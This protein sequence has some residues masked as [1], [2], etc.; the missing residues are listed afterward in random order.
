[1]ATPRSHIVTTK[2]SVAKS[3]ASLDA[4]VQ[5]GRNGGKKTQLSTQTRSFV[6]PIRTAAASHARAAN[7]TG[8]PAATRPGHLMP[9]GYVSPSRMI[10]TLGIQITRR[11]LI[12]GIIKR[13]L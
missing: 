7:Q 9:H 8:P 12:R 1:M 2:T 3:H 6:R 13:R 4:R 11:A 10:P 5:I